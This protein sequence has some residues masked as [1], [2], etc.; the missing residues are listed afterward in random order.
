MSNPARDLRKLPVHQREMDFLQAEE[1]PKL[2]AAAKEMREDLYLAVCLSIFAG[3]R[4]SELLG[5]KYGDFDLSKKSPQVQ[6]QRSYLRGSGLSAPKTETS[7]R[8]VFL[9]GE[10]ARI[11]REFRMRR[12]YP[13]DEKLVFDMGS[14]KPL[15]PDYLSKHLWKKLL[16]Y[17]EY[18]ENLRWHD[19]R[20]TYATLMLTQG[21]SLKVISNQMG[22]S[23]IKVTG[24]RYAHLLPSV[25]QE[26]A[27]RLERTVF[28]SGGSLVEESNTKGVSFCH[29]PSK[30]SF[31]AWGVS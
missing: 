18:R 29:L 27:K 26:A 30:A 19:L 21:E 8:R 23:S 16:K 10:L 13:P 22:H 1:I 11:L 9:G 24:D 15:D 7:R 2:L 4:R 25:G 20:H 3:L 6:I 14:G 31:Q 28:K 12:G 17:T 5:L